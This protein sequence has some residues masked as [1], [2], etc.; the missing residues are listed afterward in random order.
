[1]APASPPDSFDKFMIQEKTWHPVEKEKTCFKWGVASTGI[2]IKHSEK[3]PEY[4]FPWES[5]SAVHS[6]LIAISQKK[7]PVV[8]G[9]FM[10][11]PPAGSLGAWVK[12]QKLKTSVG[13]LSPRHLSFL[14]PILGR[15]GLIERSTKGN[16]ILWRV[17]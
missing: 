5:F 3:K 13:N 15:M 14:G 7:N 10:T 1:M 4:I 12:S 2:K 9:I 11:N 8:S 6:E 17:I 16:A